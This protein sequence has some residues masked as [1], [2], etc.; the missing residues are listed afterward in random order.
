MT[1]ST[2]HEAAK[3]LAANDDLRNKVMTAGSAEER[4][5]V[6]R[7]AG[8]AV[9]SH[10]DVNAAHAKMA[11]VAG[12]YLDNAISASLKPA[13]NVEEEVTN[14]AITSSATAAAAAA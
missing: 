2:F 4:A 5:T 3:A 10:A 11:G 14:V 12:G 1:A 7:E 6:L 9:P 8:V 13:T